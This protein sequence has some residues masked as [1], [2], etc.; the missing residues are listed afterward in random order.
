MLSLE[1]NNPI[2][3]SYSQSACTCMLSKPFFNCLH[4]YHERERE[5][6]YNA[7]RA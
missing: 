3:N 1:N 2:P 7:I 6:E 4:Y 5:R